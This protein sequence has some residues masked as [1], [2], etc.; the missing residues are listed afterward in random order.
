[1]NGHTGSLVDAALGMGHPDDASGPRALSS[2]PLRVGELLQELE[3]ALRARGAE[4]AISESTTG[5]GAILQCWKQLPGAPDGHRAIAEVR[6]AP[7]CQVMDFRFGLDV[8]ASD[9]TSRAAVWELAGQLDD[10]I[11]TDRFI[12]HL[13]QVDP[14]RAD[15][16]S[17]KISSGR[18]APKGDWTEI[19]ERGFQRGDAA[20]FNPGFLRDGDTRLQ[21]A[22]RI[23]TA[24]ATGPTSALCSSPHST[25]S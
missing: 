23:D 8:G 7:A 22:A 9:R 18:P 16:L 21:A 15:L 10:V 25:T 4:Q 6:W 13:R 19:V 11:R 17:S 1:M 3:P 14:D 5:Q 12:E 20:Y 24:R 2:E